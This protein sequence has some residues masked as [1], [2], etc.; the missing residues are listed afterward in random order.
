VTSFR[1]SCQVHVAA[2]GSVPLRTYLVHGDIDLC[3][4]APEGLGLKDSWA[5]KLQMK[6]EEDQR[7]NAYA[8]VRIQ[9]VQVINAEVK[10]LKCV[11]QDIVVDVSYQQIGGLC[12]LAFLERVDRLAGRDHLFKRSIL[13]VKAWCY[14]ESRLL[15]RDALLGLDCHLLSS[16]LLLRTLLWSLLLNLLN[17]K[18]ILDSK[19]LSFY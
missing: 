4:F 15:V 17:H 16:R 11:V 9:D 18:L 1:S 8:P 12:T 14:Y 10:L 19:N 6:L 5:V 2:F 3:I 13:L 7:G